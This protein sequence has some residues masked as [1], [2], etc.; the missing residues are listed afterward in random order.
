[1]RSILR[2]VAALV[3]GLGLVFFGISEI[4]TDEVDCG[5]ISMSPGETCSTTSNGSTTE[6][7]YD[8]Q[9]TDNQ[10][11]GYVMVGVGGVL[12]IGGAV[13]AVRTVRR[14][15]GAPEVVG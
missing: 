10:R 5:N 14:R 11:F 3:I 12:L 7:T 13:A 9:R 4:T 1:M 2:I 15:R 6:R 8:E